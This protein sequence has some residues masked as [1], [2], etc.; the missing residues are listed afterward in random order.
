MHR[1]ASSNISSHSCGLSIRTVTLKVIFLFAPPPPR[2]F[3]T[4]RLP[5]GLDPPEPRRP[6]PPMAAIIPPPPPPPPTGVL[7]TDSPSWKNSVRPSLVSL[8]VGDAAP[9]AAPHAAGA[10]FVRR[11]PRAW[12][13]RR[14]S[15]SSA[16]RCPGSC[17]STA[18]RRRRGRR[19]RPARRRRPRPRSRRR[20]ASCR[21]CRGCS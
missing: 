4:R 16:C 20:S 6:P 21:R 7:K 13:Y 18:C 2:G 11:R 12:A 3:G 5:A 15:G 10:I 1:Q 8:Q 9:E 14:R 19:I 17:R